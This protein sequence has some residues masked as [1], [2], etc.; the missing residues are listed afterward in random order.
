MGVNLIRLATAVLAVFLIIS[1]MIIFPMPI[2][3]GAAMMVVGLVLLISVSARVARCAR[4]FRRRHPGANKIIQKVEDKLPDS[5][6]NTL[7]RTDP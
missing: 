7:R 6:R 3:V 1:G 5:L 4:L 2:P